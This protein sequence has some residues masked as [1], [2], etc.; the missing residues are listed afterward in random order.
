MTAILS[1]Q[2][3]QHG[4][5]AAH[6]SSVWQECMRAVRERMHNSSIWLEKMASTPPCPAWCADS[7][8]RRRQQQL[9]LVLV[10]C[11]GCHGV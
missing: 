2:T 4:V 8:S 11:D 7:W 10:L 9:V 5:T 6:D 3:W 1:M